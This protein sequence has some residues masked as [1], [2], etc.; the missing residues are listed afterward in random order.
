VIHEINNLL[1]LD[2][3]E[4]GRLEELY[5]LEPDW[6]LY[7]IIEDNGSLRVFTARDDNKLVGYFTVVSS[8]SLHSKG[9]LIASNDVIFLHPAYRKGFVG[10]KLF[11]FAEKCVKED[12]FQ[13][14]QICYTEKFDISPILSMLGYTKVETKF[15]KRLN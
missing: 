4:V 12:G 13:Q 10:V 14:L 6:E 5:P 9:K 3:Q 1:Y 7:Q 2:W 8:P 11:K 15:E